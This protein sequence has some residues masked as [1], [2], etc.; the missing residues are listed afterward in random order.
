VR[1]LLNIL[2]SEVMKLKRN[3]LILSCS[4]IAILIPVFMICCDLYYLNKGTLVHD[5]AIEWIGS[6]SLLCQLIIYPILSGFIITF[7]IQKEYGESTIINTLT[8]PVNKTKF[9]FGK[10]IVWFLW[11]MAI[12]AVFLFITFAG[13]YLLYGQS[14]LST[15]LSQIVKQILL[16]GLFDFLTLIPVV[17]IAIIQRKSF[18]PS[19][20]FCCIIMAIGFAGLYWSKLLSSIIPWS[21]VSTLCV[22]GLHSSDI[23]PYISIISCGIIG[24]GLAIYSFRHQDL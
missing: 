19:L 4:I 14:P 1:A 24:L 23:T 3:K 7:S 22:T 6:L 18:Y 12:T 9:L 17:W 10:I 8:A 13:V 5:T 16:I 2:S 15:N 21:A 20:L 11:H